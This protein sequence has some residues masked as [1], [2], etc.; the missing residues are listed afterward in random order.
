MKPR[1]SYLHSAVLAVSVALPQ[2]VM[3]TPAG[4][5]LLAVGPAYVQTAN[6]EVHPARKGLQVAAGE[7]IMTR[8]GGYVHVRMRDGGL[9]AI[10]PD[11]VL[12]IQVFE[13]PVDHPEKGRV[14]YRLQQ[15]VARS[16]TGAI[17]EA[18]KEAFRMNTPVA[19]IGVRGTDFVTQTDTLV[20][21]VSINSGAVVV[22]PFANNQGCKAEGFGACLS[23]A[24]VLRAGKEVGYVEVG[25]QDGAPRLRKEQRLPLPPAH[26]DE[27]VAILQENRAASLEQGIGVQTAKLPD[28]VHWGRWSVAEGSASPSVMDLVQAG[29]SIHLVNF[30]FGVGVERL[31]DT[32]PSQGSIGFQLAGGEAVVRQLDGAYSPASLAS[33]Q[34]RVDFTSQTFQANAKVTESNAQHVLTAA[35][36]VDRP[37]YLIADPTLS[38]SALHTVLNHDLNTAGSVFTKTLDDGRTV[39][40]SAIWKR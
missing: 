38:N 40:G 17:G 31:P 12:D 20:T 35:G 3:A 5:V 21:R 34:L 37:G 13:Y 8:T 2:A 6:G 33:G 15:G 23:N 30:L 25:A 19:A 32:L 29:K 7:R 26:P 14:R 28:S 39:L 22:A 4:D 36:R 9:V 11:S 24:L 18:N 27:P 16:V 10:R 1:F